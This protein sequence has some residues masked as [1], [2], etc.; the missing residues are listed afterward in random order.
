MPVIGIFYKNYVAAES[1]I[2]QLIDK[3]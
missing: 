1:E 2:T 3:V